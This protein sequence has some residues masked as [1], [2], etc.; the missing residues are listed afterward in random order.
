MQR[1]AGNREGWTRE[2]ARRVG[3]LSAVMVRVETRK[4]SAVCDV[5]G[6]GANPPT[7]SVMF[8]TGCPHS[9]AD[10]SGVSGAPLPATAYSAFSSGSFKRLCACQECSRALP[11]V[12]HDPHTVCIMGRGSRIVSSRCEECA[13]WDVMMVDSARVYQAKVEQ[14]HTR[15]ACA[16][17]QGSV[18]ASGSRVGA[19]DMP[20]RV[21]QVDLLSLMGS[22]TP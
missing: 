13:G 18:G 15:Y 10:S 9:G 20:H 2:A 1:T 16:K 8:I 7:D 12:S 14:C 11:N 6:E 4:H 22:V 3:K 17:R 19:G 21:V 5:L